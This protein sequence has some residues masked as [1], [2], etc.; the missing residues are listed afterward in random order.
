MREG[1][2]DREGQSVCTAFCDALQ[3]QHSPW[4]C[5]AKM[6]LGWCAAVCDV[7][8]VREREAEQRV[9]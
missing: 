8:N 5:C 3:P 2:N 4:L 6:S 9:R 1:E 7:C